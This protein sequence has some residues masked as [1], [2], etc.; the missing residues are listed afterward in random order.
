[1][2]TVYV[3]RKENL[4]REVV[5]RIPAASLRQGEGLRRRFSREIR[6]LGTSIHSHVARP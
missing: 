3:A 4:D 2:A 5:V 1:M 6:R